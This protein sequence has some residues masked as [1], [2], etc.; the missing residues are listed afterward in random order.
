VVPHSATL[1]E[2]EV[3]HRSSSVIDALKA[4]RREF[5][6]EKIDAVLAISPFWLPEHSFCV[7]LSVR[8][9]H[10]ADYQGY[11]HEV[12][13]EYRGAPALA[14]LLLEEGKKAGLPV[15]SR[16][17]GAD[18]SATVALHFLFPKREV[19]LIPLSSTELSLEKSLAWG[20]CLRRA[21][22]ISGKNVLLLSG[23][24]L[25]H[26]L[27]ACLHWEDSIAA[28]I[29][30]QKVLKCLQAGRGTDVVKMD[31]YWID[32]GN[33]TAEFRDLFIFLG[34][35]GATAKGKLIAYDG[36]PGVGWAVM[37]FD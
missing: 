3:H 18:H 31:P 8:H 17:H 27:T 30:D 6:K 16:H 29:Y 15:L 37:K 20:R 7:D 4:L 26:N 25:S 5:S 35:C 9:R 28:V 24:G 36:A 19:P 11:P 2:D 14:H 34:A 10:S 12:K 22:E 13:H 32:V 21:V 23:G 33:P 1:L